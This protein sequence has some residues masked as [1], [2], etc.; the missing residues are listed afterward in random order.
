M[1]DIH[2]YSGF[3]KINPDEPFRFEV[4]ELEVEEIYKDGTIET[5]RPYFISRM[6][7]TY[8]FGGNSGER[9]NRVFEIT[10]RMGIIYSTDK[11]KCMDFVT[12]KRKEVKEMADNLLKNL[13][14]SKVEDLTERFCDE[15]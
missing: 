10:D 7:S 6:N 14:Q 13:N 3:V 2:L 5:K 15:S 4:D 11:Q 9:L 8:Y 1:H 12:D